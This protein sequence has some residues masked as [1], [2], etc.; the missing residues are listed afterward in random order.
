MDK[1]INMLKVKST[2]DI[3]DALTQNKSTKFYMAPSKPYV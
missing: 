2:N 1:K 3:V